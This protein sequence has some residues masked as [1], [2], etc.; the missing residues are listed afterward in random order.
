M[1]SYP[2]LIPLP[3]G[4]VHRIVDAVRPLGFERV[5]GAFDRREIMSDG[6]AGVLRSEARYVAWIEGR[7]D[8]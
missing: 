2:N 8:A 7:A 6:H 3:A 1:R 5:Y 4:T